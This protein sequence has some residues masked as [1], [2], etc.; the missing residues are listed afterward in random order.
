MPYNFGTLHF[1]F[2]NPSLVLWQEN[3]YNFNHSLIRKARMKKVQTHNCLQSEYAPLRHNALTF[4][5]KLIYS[6]IT[7]INSN[8]TILP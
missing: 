2:P 4:A 7:I 1:A 8:I 5:Q 6:I 3:K